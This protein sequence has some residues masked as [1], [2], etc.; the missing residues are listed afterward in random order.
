LQII[1]NTSPP[2]HKA[3]IEQLL[4]EADMTIFCV[5]FL[6]NSGI[7]SILHLIKDKAI[8]YVGTDHYITEPTALKKLIRANHKVYLVKKTKST[9]HPKIY[10]SA[11]GNKISILTGSS[12]LTGGGLESNLEVSVLLQTEKGSSIDE[13]FNIMINDFSLFASHLTSE[14]AVSQ[15]EREFDMFW[16]KH[17]KADKEF[18]K[19]LDAVHKLDLTK[20]ATYF[21]D[22]MAEVGPDDYKV[23]ISDYKTI[24]KLLDRM[25]ISDINAPASFLEHYETIATSFYSSDLL[26]GKTIFAKE[27]KRIIAATKFIKENIS[28]DASYVYEGALKLI[29]PVPKF[30]V[31]GLTEIMNAY[32]PSKFSVVNGRIIKSLTKLGFVEISNTNKKYFNRIAYGQLNTL[33]TEI[34]E[35]TNARDLGEVDHFLSWYYKF[36]VKD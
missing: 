11:K 36:Y 21:N 5:A 30:G 12:N 28:N 35:I 24:R 17:K 3:V 34:Q 22:F 33:I 6:K 23:R 10:Y 14:L 1:T 26:R 15:Y 13:S 25:I 7:N 9:F 31:N 27:Y 8:F 16:K 20:L 18:K 32:N 19:E 2:T 4:I 29:L